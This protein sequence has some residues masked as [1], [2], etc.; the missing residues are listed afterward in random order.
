[1]EEE[2]FIRTSTRSLKP[3]LNCGFNNPMSFQLK[4]SVK[5]QTESEQQKDERISLYRQLL[6]KRTE[7][8]YS[9]DIMPYIIASNEI[10]MK[11]AQVKPCTLNQ[12]RKMQCK[13]NW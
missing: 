10:L 6:S 8:A 7:M 13:L 4:E 1:M 12:L 9:M 3:T 11:I 5:N 2:N